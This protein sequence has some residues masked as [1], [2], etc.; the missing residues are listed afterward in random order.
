V[1]RLTD[2]IAA[3]G[4]RLFAVI[5]QAAEAANVGL[6]LRPTTLVLFGARSPAENP[7]LGG[8]RRNQRHLPLAGRA[9]RPLPPDS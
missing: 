6:Q 4:M 8:R 1:T 3:G 5:D 9:G 2:L 7:G